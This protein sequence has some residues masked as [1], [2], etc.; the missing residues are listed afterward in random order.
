MIL[1]CI[2]FVLPPTLPITISTF[3]YSPIAVLAVLII[4]IVLWYAR[5]KK[6]FM[7]HLDKEQLAIDE[8]KLLDEIDD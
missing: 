4:S 8:K 2:L 1:I 6:H 5:G 3:N 7:Q